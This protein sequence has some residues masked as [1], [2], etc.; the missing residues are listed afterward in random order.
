MA[1]K[2]GGKEYLSDILRGIGSG[3]S[4]RPTVPMYQAQAADMPEAAGV[5]PEIF[6]A[7]MGERKAGLGREQ[8]LGIKEQELGLKEKTLGLQEERNKLAS[9]KQKADDAYRNKMLGFKRDWLAVSIK[10]ATQTDPAFGSLSQAAMKAIMAKD[11]TP[12]DVQLLNAWTYEM[13]KRG[14]D[15]SDI[16]FQN[17]PSIWET[18]KS[19]VG[20]GGQPS[21]KPTPKSSPKTKGKDSLGLGL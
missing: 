21:P 20:L 17:D 10:H 16:D 5:S 9:E 2:Y 4:G 14:I 18:L 6:Q 15:T 8:S 19:A 11:K 12:E 13:N 7:L 3:I 1:K